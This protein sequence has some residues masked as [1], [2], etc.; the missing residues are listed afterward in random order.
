[1]KSTNLNSS[2][3]RSAL[4]EAYKNVG[5]YLRIMISQRYI[6]PLKFC[7]QF[8]FF[9][10]ASQSIDNYPQLDDVVTNNQPFKDQMRYMYNYETTLFVPNPVKEQQ[11]VAVRFQCNVNIRFR[12]QRWGI[13]KSRVARMTVSNMETVVILILVILFFNLIFNIILLDFIHAI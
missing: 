9:Y 3:V 6:L 10:Q 4:L 13:V 8:V 5:A 11:T 12:Q 2:K 7:S 1:M